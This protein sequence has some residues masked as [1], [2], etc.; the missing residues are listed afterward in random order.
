LFHP[1]VNVLVQEVWDGRVWAARPMRVVEETE[2]ASVLWFPRG[3]SWRAPTSPPTRARAAS[4]AERLSS[5]IALADWVFVE[6]EWEA[7]TLQIWPR[8]AWHSIW[9]SWRPDGSRWGY[10]GNIQLPFER[11]R[12]GFR[13]MDLVL[14]VIV[15]LDGS[16]WLKD[17]DE[18][19][20]FVETGVVDADLENRIRSEAEAVAARAERR[21]P[22]FDGSWDAWR[23]DPDWATPALPAGWEDVCR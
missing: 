21:E 10:Y 5:A 11:T 16:W 9:V 3:T 19:A 2:D 14:D 4:R 17:E 13:T 15:E 8:D 6:S 23:P 18:L 20:V 22:P 12:C 1:L 7:S